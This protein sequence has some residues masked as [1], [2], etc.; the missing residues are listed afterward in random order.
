MANDNWYVSLDSK[1]FTILKTRLVKKLGSKYPKLFCTM[2]DSIDSEPVFPTV[3]IHT[4][5]GVEM[6]A[7]LVNESINAIL[8][9]VQVD[10]TDNE[11]MND[12]RIVTM[13]VL[14]QLKLLHFNIVGMPIYTTEGNVYR[15]VLRARRTIGSDDSLT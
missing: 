10:V 14:N 11:S 5:Q 7:D 2:A 4:L 13:E 6:G 8:N 12:C 3:Y 9:T 1:I 15:G